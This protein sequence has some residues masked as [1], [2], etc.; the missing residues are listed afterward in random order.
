MNGKRD[1]ELVGLNGTNSGRCCASHVGCGKFVKANDLI[2]LK[3][4]IIVDENFST[5]EAIKAILLKDGA[6]CCTIGFLPSN[7]V[8]AYGE[9]YDGKHA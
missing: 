9:K 6:E 8:L 7:I 1:G 3:R 5:E 4:C 2:R